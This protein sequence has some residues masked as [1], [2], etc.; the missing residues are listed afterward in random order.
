MKD[1]KVLANRLLEPLIKGKLTV[2]AAI[3][4]NKFFVG[5]SPAKLC[6]TCKK[7][8]VNYPIDDMTAMNIFIEEL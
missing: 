7:E 5:K 8:V 1:I 3:C 4:C 2:Y 6:K